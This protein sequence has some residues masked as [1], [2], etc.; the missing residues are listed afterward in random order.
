MKIQHSYFIRISN[1]QVIVAAGE[2]HFSTTMIKQQFK[3]FSKITTSNDMHPLRR[4]AFDNHHRFRK[5]NFNL[6]LVDETY[7]IALL[8]CD[9]EDNIAHTFRHG[10]ESFDNWHQFIDQH[11]AFDSID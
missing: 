11:F 7:K 2:E 10:I 1:M 3:T 9:S 4:L 8:I 5:F 6:R